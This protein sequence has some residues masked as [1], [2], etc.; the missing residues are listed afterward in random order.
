MQA[1]ILIKLRW[2][3]YLAMDNDGQI[4][5]HNYCNSD[6]VMLLVVGTRCLSE[7]ILSIPPSHLPP[8]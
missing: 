8:H 5:Q 3:Y 4:S 2:M 1:P 7:Y 6:N